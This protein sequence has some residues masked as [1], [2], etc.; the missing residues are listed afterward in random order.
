MSGLTEGTAAADIRF[1]SVAGTAEAVAATM[2]G[3]LPVAAIGTGAGVT[4]L[5]AASFLIVRRRHRSRR[6]RTT[7]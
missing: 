7:G 4:A 6:E 1:P 2:D 3:H 5:A